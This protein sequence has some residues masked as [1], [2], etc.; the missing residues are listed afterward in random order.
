MCRGNLIIAPA[1]IKVLIL[2]LGRSVY[3]VCAG[4]PSIN[5]SGKEGFG[6]K[7]R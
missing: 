6:V 1:R 5:R 7:K 4:N 2:D 3:P